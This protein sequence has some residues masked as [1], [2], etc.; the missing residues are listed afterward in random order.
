MRQGVEWYVIFSCVHIFSLLQ[1]VVQTV[2][3]L[4][5]ILNCVHTFLLCD[6]HLVT[7]TTT[8]R[9]CLLQMGRTFQH[10]N[11]VEKLGKWR[12]PMAGILMIFFAYCQQVSVVKYWRY[13]F[14]DL[15]V[16]DG[17]CAV[18]VL[19]DIASGTGPLVSEAHE[20]FY[21]LSYTKFS[22]VDEYIRQL[23]VVLQSSSFGTL[24]SWARQIALRR[25]FIHGLS[26]NICQ[27][28]SPQ[29]LMS[30][31]QVLLGVCRHIR[32]QATVQPKLLHPARNTML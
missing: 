32:E 6:W 31:E 11:G 8:T 12:R 22:S 2:F 24:P 30:F 9:S 27:P 23:K 21:A 10:L 25:Q 19:E 1:W 26:P 29:E 17:S 5:T 20:T 16:A 3:I 7:T 4:F 15:N 14:D 18:S 13:K 28:L